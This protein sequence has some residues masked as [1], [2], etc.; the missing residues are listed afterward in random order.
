MAGENGIDDGDSQKLQPLLS[1]DADGE[2]MCYKKTSELEQTIGCI[3]CGLP[4]HL[5]CLRVFPD[6]VR[7]IV[8]YVCRDCSDNVLKWSSGLAG[9]QRPGCQN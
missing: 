5:Y 2:C 4:G 7:E 1:V 3:T 8:K 6:T 9:R